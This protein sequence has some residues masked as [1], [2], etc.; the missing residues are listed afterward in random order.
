M[1]KITTI[2][3][4]AL[5]AFVGFAA[6]AQTTLGTPTVVSPTTQYLTSAPEVKIVWMN[7]TTPVS[8]LQWGN[9]GIKSQTV[10]VTINGLMYTVP[11]SIETVEWES[12]GK[13]LSAPG[14]VISFENYTDYY[15]VESNGKAVTGTY[16]YTI[17][18]D[19]IALSSNINA[20]NN[21]LQYTFTVYP[22]PNYTLTT[23]PATSKNKNMTYGPYQ[24]APVTFTATNNA[25]LVPTGLVTDVTVSV[26]DMAGTAIEQ[27]WNADTKTPDY[28]DSVVT[29][30]NKGIVWNGTQNFQINLTGGR[31]P[32][33][34]VG[35]YQATGA[36]TDTLIFTVTVPAQFVCI[37]GTQINGNETKYVF[38]VTRTLPGFQVL[39]PAAE[40]GQNLFLLSSLDNVTMTWDFNDLIDDLSTLKAYL[41]YSYYNQFEGIYQT[42]AKV[43]P[44][45]VNRYSYLYAQGGGN[46]GTVS[47]L[48]TLADETDP[49]NALDIVL[50]PYV[51]RF[52]A[53]FYNL[54]IPAENVESI[55][56]QANAFESIYFFIYPT[57]AAAR[58]TIT[59]TGLIAIDWNQDVTE[60]IILG[61][62]LSWGL[63]Y[64]YSYDEQA[65]PNANSFYL[66][67]PGTKAYLIDNDTNEPV[68]Y[69][70]KNNE[71]LSGT[72]YIDNA[73]I[74]TLGASYTI[75]LTSLITK[76]YL[77]NGSYT[78]VLPEGWSFLYDAE[79]FEYIN[80]EQ[81]IDIEI[82]NGATTGVESIDAVNTNDSKVI[83]NLQGVKVNS[84]VN[85]LSNGIYIIDGKKVVVRK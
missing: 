55:Y 11:A 15:P 34:T 3:S 40:A 23:D 61:A 30:A 63:E 9:T 50:G 68:M 84:D 27:F 52:G 31:Y 70:P 1:K 2:A 18:S 42:S 6:N 75:N 8:S 41:Y 24:L 37:G 46:G 13:Q 57:Y 49:V 64:F 81:Y 4:A 69:P 7:G 12:N 44:I 51:E 19:F 82:S 56:G 79:G 76:G 65:T 67:I 26:T 74:T 10:S 71:G 32:V 39:S 60:D 29:V 80:P 66:Y 16:V 33:P 59:P 48:M 85:A 77:T 35:Q 17:P 78:L 43:E 83:F 36:R 45:P 22:T 58:S 28:P 73:N 5:M 72:I 25:S 38:Y 20:S 54:A 62:K 14:L 53:G 21:Q 47:P